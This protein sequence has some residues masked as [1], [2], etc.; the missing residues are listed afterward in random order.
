[1]KLLIIA[2]SMTA[3]LT[4]CAGSGTG[5]NLYSPSQESQL[6]DQY[7]AEISKQMKIMND[8]VLN[9][10]VNQLGQRMISKG[11][12]NSE[13]KYKFHVVDSS[14]VNAFAIPGGHVYINLALLKEA[15]NEAELVGVVGHELGH[16]EHHHGAKKMTDA[17]LLQLAGQVASK[18]AGQNG[19]RWVGLGVSLFGTAGLLKY[20]RNAE[21]ESDVMG[22][23]IL[24]RT[25]Y[26]TQA[27]PSFFKKLQKIENERGVLGGGLSELLATHPP[28]G[29]RIAA[30]QAHI[31]QLPAQN[32]PIVNSPEFEKIREY[33]APMKPSKPQTVK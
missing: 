14:E 18:A 6:G 3:L 16:V 29:E 13:F 11:I 22:V 5:L 7:H 10:Y 33:I 4:G 20:G 21:L 17:Q 30:A 15:E 31:A 23:D 9:N 26:T 25:G 2:L 24:Q 8:P 28:T 19:G 1:M 27:L 32:N 12:G